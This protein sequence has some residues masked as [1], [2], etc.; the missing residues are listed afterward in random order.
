MAHSMTWR[1]IGLTELF[2]RYV[3]GG[4]VILLCCLGLSCDSA[5]SAVPLAELVMTPHVVLQVPET[6]LGL[7]QLNIATIAPYSDKEFFVANFENVFLLNIEKGVMEHVQVDRLSAEEV[8]RRGYQPT[9]LFYDPDANRLFVANYLKNNVMIFELLGGRTLRLIETLHHESLISPESLWL[10]QA[11]R[12]LVSANFDGH[13]VSAFL[14]EPHVPAK[15]LWRSPLRLAHGITVDQGRVYAT[16]LEDR[17]LVELD[18]STGRPLRRMGALGWRVQAG[19]FLWPTSLY[20][21]KRGNIVISDADTGLISLLDVR[22]LTIKQAVG[23]NGPGKAFLNQPYFTAIVKDNFLTISTKQQRFIYGQYPDFRPTKAFVRSGEFWG[24]FSPTQPDAAL[25]FTG[26]DEYWWNS[27][28][29]VDLLNCGYLIYRDMLK[30]DRSSRWLNRIREARGAE[31]C[32]VI[33]LGYVATPLGMNMFKQV[34]MLS[35]GGW[36]L[37]LSPQSSDGPLFVRSIGKTL[38]AVRYPFGRNDCWIISNEIQ[39]PDGKRDVERMVEQVG[40]FV[41]AMERERCATGVLLQKKYIDVLMRWYKSIGV[42]ERYLSATTMKASLREAFTSMTG[43]SSE[44]IQSK[45]LLE[46]VYSAWELTAECEDRPRIHMLAGLVNQVQEQLSR[47]AT[48]DQL[49]M[50]TVFHAGG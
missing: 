18:L 7:G 2:T 1:H 19:Q 26:W 47:I 27:G 49:A 16:G 43:V 3:L 34:Q 11:S 17:V 31:T 41:D 12:I 21:D 46:E 30:P 39:C 24:H 6:A 33:R 9:G 50:S 48:I 42:G 4:G 5:V 40:G 15:F 45:S 22:T 14:L 32:P 37:F 8:A 36:Y 44:G 20:P 29:H 28:P 23:G 10:D 38:Y 25:G 13:S 35:A